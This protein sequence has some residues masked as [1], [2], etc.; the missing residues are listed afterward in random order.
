MPSPAPPPPAKHT[1]TNPFIERLIRF[2]MPYFAAVTLDTDAARAEIIETIASYGARTRGE[3]IKTV[4]IIAFSFSALDVLAEAEATEM[5]PALRLRFR[6]C[7]NNLNRSSQASEATLAKSLASDAPEAGDYASEPV[8]DMPEAAFEK[9][10]ALAKT[11][12]A[13]YRDSLSA[14]HPVAAGQPVPFC[15]QNIRAPDAPIANHP[16]PRPAPT[17]LTAPN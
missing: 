3:M 4:Q 7:A 1:A 16:A 14:T 17:R 13:S 9:S 11:H 12:I 2:L 5:A 15:Q 8:D 10:L 6:S